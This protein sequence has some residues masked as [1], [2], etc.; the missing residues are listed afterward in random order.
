M[1]ER[2][3]YETDIL[4]WSEQQAA[5]LRERASRRDLPNALDLAHVAAEIEDLGL[6]QLNGVKS[7]IPLILEHI[8][9][10]ATEPDAPADR[11]R[12]REIS[13]WQSELGDRFSPSMRQRIDLDEIWRQAT[14]ASAL[15]VNA[16]ATSPVGA[17]VIDAT[18]P[19]SLD[20]AV[21]DQLSPADL[22]DRLRAALSG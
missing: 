8:L 16:A 19:L 13:D 12:H 9:K 14:K 5:V 15:E 7:G 20:D 2:D 3:L 18:C 6:S 17:P 11:H 21:S 10:C 4:A 1:A 22:V